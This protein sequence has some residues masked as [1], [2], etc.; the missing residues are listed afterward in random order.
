MDKKQHSL[1]VPNVLVILLSAVCFYLLLKVQVFASEYLPNKDGID[2]I[3]FPAGIVFLAIL[4]GR[5]YGALGIFLALI[6]SYISRF[7]DVEILVVVGMVSFS[8]FVQL[9]V[10]NSFLLVVG[11]GK[12]L[13]NLTFFHVTTLVLIFSL[14][15][16]ICH[17]LNLLIIA[18]K[19]VGWFES[20][21]ALSTLLGVFVSL[22][23]V[24]LM[25][26]L[27][28]YFFD[29]SVSKSTRN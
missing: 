3:Y 26:K 6:P 25:S 9:M 10:I 11:V 13:E 17:Y 16:S 22:I 2:S 24:W 1:Y 7:P 4:I 5:A 8:L 27:G 14:S 20:K 28:K 12:K 23:V 18:D 29:N 21:I 15:H 19:Q